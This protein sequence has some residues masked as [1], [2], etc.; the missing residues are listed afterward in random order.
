MKRKRKQ[1]EATVQK[2]SKK[3]E[4]KVYEMDGLTFKNIEGLKYYQKLLRLVED[5]VIFSFSLD[6][7]MLNQPKSKYGANKIVINDIKFDSM[8]EGNYY[9]Y[10]LNEKEKGSILDYELK[11]SFVLQPSFK[12]NEKRILQI[13][14]IADFKIFLPTGEIIIVD[15]KGVVTPDFK[16]KQK[17]FEFK[18]P[19]LSLKVLKYVESYGGWIEWDDWVKEKKRRDKEKKKI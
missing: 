1:D 7:L 17:M 18:Y 10:L 15:T 12:K 8:L 13:K 4:K 3:K 2:K 6:S 11:P 14:Y 5:K 19:E 9:L 16:L